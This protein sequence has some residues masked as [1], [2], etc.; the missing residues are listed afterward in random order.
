MK[1]LYVRIGMLFLLCLSCAGL[2]AQEVP[3][4]SNASLEFIL[5]PVSEGFS[6][7]IHIRRSN[8]FRP[9]KKEPVY[10]GDTVYR[11]H[12]RFSIHSTDF[13]GIAYDVT[14]KTLYIDRN[15]NQDLTDDGPGYLGE[16][17]PSGEI[18]F[19]G[20]TIDLTY[21]EFSYQLVYESRY[22]QG[23]FETYDTGLC[24]GWEA[25]VEIAGT[26]CTMG[27]SDSDI[28]GVLSSNDIFRF[29]HKRNR[30]A[31][32]PFCEPDEYMRQTPLPQWLYFEGQSYRLNSEF[33]VVDNETVIA[34]TLTP[35]TEDMMTISFEGQFVSRVL[36]RD[37]NKEYGL[38]DWPVPTMHIPKGQ[39]TPYEVCLL[40]SFYGRPWKVPPLED[41]NNMLLKT[42][43]PLHQEISA[44][45]EGDSLSLSYTLRGIDNTHYVAS[46]F[47]EEN[48]PHFTIYQGDQ[49]V[50]AGQ[51][52]Y[53]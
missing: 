42:G 41:G 3:Q 48:R 22:S 11:E 7:R 38:L 36:L 43:G 25:E 39:Y 8:R 35:I 21:G 4:P 17:L 19:S 40:D 53:G 24:S 14:G 23:A 1:F 47:Y 16:I 49:Q 12:Y 29:D 18:L 28:D 6:S 27:I 15:R 46:R 26:R 50:A 13:V 52:E 10:A 30:E 51:F 33:R 37:I 32:L 31:Q 9:F 45:R 44:T 34:V 2:Y 20:L 5:R